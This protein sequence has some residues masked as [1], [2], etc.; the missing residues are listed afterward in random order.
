MWGIDSQ[1]VL[2]RRIRTSR[3]KYRRWYD[4]QYQTTKLRRHKLCSLPAEPGIVRIRDCHVAPCS[5]F[6]GLWVNW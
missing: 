6:Y 4:I 5:F 3:G 2:C 1:M